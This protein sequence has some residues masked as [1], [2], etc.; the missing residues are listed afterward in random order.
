[1][2]KMPSF[3]DVEHDAAA[4][5]HGITGM[6]AHMLPAHN[7]H[8]PSSAPPHAEP[9]FTPHQTSESSQPEEQVTTPQQPQ[10]RVVDS[11]HAITSEIRDNAFV[12]LL[13]DLR[14]GRTLSEAQASHFVALIADVE[15]A[16]VVQQ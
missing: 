8:V 13:I 10:A 11:L 12:A 9:T 3:E 5:G 6:L 4:V 7:P 2:P 14:V 1:M 16:H 15:Q